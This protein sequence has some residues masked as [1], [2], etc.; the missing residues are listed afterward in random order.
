MI[1]GINKQEFVKLKLDF[2]LHKSKEHNILN[3]FS[4]I[5]FMKKLKGNECFGSE[6]DILCK[7]KKNDMSWLPYETA[8][9]LGYKNIRFFLKKF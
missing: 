7:I 3:Y 8:L 4:Y 2:E 1:C 9:S 6:Y 5:K